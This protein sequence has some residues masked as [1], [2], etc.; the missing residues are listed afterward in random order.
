MDIKMPGMSGVEAFIKIKAIDPHVT[1]IMMTA[2]AAED[3]IKK[4]I[5]EGAYTVLHKPFEIKDILKVVEESLMGRTLILAIEKGSDF[6][7]KLQDLFENKGIRVTVVNTGED[8]VKSVQEKKFQIIILNTKLP[9]ID[10]LET[11]KRVKTIRPDVGV[12]MIAGESEKH[13]IE[14]ALEQGSTACIRKPYDVKDLLKLV[15][16]HMQ[17]G[18]QR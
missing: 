10:G 11:L 15:Q 2:F 12:I 6:R 13:L 14:E 4:A 17:S 7:D 1:V 3:D 9:G 18:T 8:C 16:K 5:R